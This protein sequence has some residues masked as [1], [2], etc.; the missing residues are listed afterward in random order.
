MSDPRS[1]TIALLLAGVLL[2]AAGVLFVS[3]DDDPAT[4]TGAARTDGRNEE[5]GTGA[6][7]APMAAPD[8]HAAAPVADQRA[9]AATAATESTT[10]PPVLR[11][12]LR[13]LHPAA[14]WTTKLHLNVDGRDDVAD[15]WLDHDAL[16]EVDATGGAR[17]ELPKWWHTATSTKGRITAHDDHYLELRH[18][19][20][21]ALDVAE[22]LVLDV[23]VVA[24]LEGRVLDSR[25]AGIAAARVKAFAVQNGSPIDDDVAENNTRIDG[26][27]SLQ[28][29]PAVP[30]LLLVVP[31]ETT[32]GRGLEAIGD[33]ALAD[34]GTA[35][36]DLLPASTR[37]T[38]PVGHTTR[39][40]DFVLADAAPLQGSVA[41]A[42]GK[43][44]MLATV[45]AL[46]RGGTTFRISTETSVQRHD[47]GTL[48]PIVVTTTEEDGTFSLPAV[49]GA[50]VDVEVAML[51][52]A[53]LVGAPLVQ[54]ALPPQRVK[55][56]VPPPTVLRV[57]R[58][59]KPIAKARIDFDSGET[60]STDARGQ[61][62][63][64]VLGKPVTTHASHQRLLSPRIALGTEH[65]GTTVTLELAE[66]LCPVSIEFEGAF[67][68][69]NT[70]VEW[71][72]TDGRV[73]RE[74]LMRDDRGGPFQVFL[75][76]GQYHLRA[77]PGGGERNG[78]FLLPVERD[79]AVTGEPVKLV[80]P[81]VFGGGF[82]VHA[83]DSNGL[84]VAGTCQVVDGTGQDL[85]DFFHV[86]EDGQQN[87]GRPGEVLPGAPNTFARILPPGD[88]ELLFDF[89]GHGARRHRLT[90]RPREMTDV[91]VRL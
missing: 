64:I 20:D 49:A 72:S 30:L 76:P 80:L 62:Q 59:G 61:T 34:N 8:P 31:M 51:A 5:S 66:A 79:V 52:E 68:V 53:L 84:H 33:G 1:R 87:Q 77:G 78:V 63:V 45:R 88:Y 32:S 21:G 12:R 54:T 28:I 37:V 83:T 39:V 58:D 44:I 3:R 15:A 70:V 86:R 55:F 4:G 27:F 25:G 43:P 73:G 71:R 22:E 10:P 42:D 29:P 26:S 2:L 16:A 91:R 7:T 38:G 23:Q 17:F 85:T 69:R 14:P 81:A 89:E 47:D 40:P 18:Q 24:V 60:L 36:S 35:R 19:W 90:I 41:W 11:V 9:P 13:G 48:S 50:V 82:V 46:P 6:T 65:A 74:H 56:V 75:E 57:V 67:R